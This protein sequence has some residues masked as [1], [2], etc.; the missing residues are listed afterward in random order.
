[1]CDMTHLC[2]LCLKIICCCLGL[3]GLNLLV[4]VYRLELYGAVNLYDW[5]TLHLEVSIGI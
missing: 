1:M 3:L 4:I 2:S 5:C